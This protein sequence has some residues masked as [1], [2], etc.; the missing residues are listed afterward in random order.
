MGDV[1]QQNSFIDFYFQYIGK[2]IPIDY[3]QCLITP[4]KS[5]T[6]YKTQLYIIT[7]SIQVLFNHISDISNSNT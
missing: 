6:E 4:S 5:N 7:A 3:K 2:A 1:C